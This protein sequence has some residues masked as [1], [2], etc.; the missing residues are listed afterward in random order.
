[1]L[2]V[3]LRKTT[4]CI[5]TFYQHRGRILLPRCRMIR[6]LILEK[7]LTHLKSITKDRRSVAPAATN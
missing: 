6:T 1:M 4:L 7:Y 5:P 3:M 2:Q